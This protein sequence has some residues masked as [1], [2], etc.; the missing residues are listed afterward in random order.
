MKANHIALGIH[1]HRN[2]AVFANRHLFLE[3]LPAM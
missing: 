3:N 2:E 1:D